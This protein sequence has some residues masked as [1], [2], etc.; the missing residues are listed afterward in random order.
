MQTDEDVLLLLAE[1]GARLHALLLR[2]TLRTDVAE[3][4][5]QDLF[6]K[7]LHDSRC[8]DA[9]SPL[10]YAVRMATNL[11]FDYRR[12]AQ[13]A[14]RV[15]SI[16]RET[17]SSNHS[18][19]ADLVRREQFERLLDAVGQLPEGDREIIVLRFL[20]QQEY[21]AI[22]RQLEKTPHRVRALCH[23]AIKKLRAILDTTDERSPITKG[24]QR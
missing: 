14:A 15:E 3:D 23:K 22:A 11:A 21:D 20:E 19:L 8:L 16:A 13:R 5:L 17:P 1:H 18:P 6:L 24:H 4:L 2:L 12:T 10:A 9:R 7:L